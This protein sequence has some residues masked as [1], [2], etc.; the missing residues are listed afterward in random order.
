[1]NWTLLKSAYAFV[2]PWLKVRK[3]HVIMPSGVEMDDFYVV[4]ANDWV[5]VI[6]ITDDGNFIIE[7]Q[8]RHGVQ[9][10]CFEL[11]ARN[12]SEREQPIDAAKREL[13]EESGYAGGE[14]TYFGQFIPNTSG[15]NNTCHS[16]IAKGVKKVQEKQLEETEDIKIHLVTLTELKELLGDEKIVEAVMQALLY[17][18]LLEI[19]TDLNNYNYGLSNSFI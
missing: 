11:P 19:S 2:C 6:A 7:E 12:V 16:F 13:L 17:K 8:Y 14:W 9:K 15:M 10:V 1:M 4:E 18:Y 3:D 5:N